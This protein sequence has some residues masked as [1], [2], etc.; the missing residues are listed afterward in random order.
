MM[1]S[2]AVAPDPRVEKEAQAL[3]KAGHEVTVLAWD[4]AGEAPRQ[5]RREGFVIERLGPPAVHGGGL[6]SLPRYREFWRAASSRAVDLEADVVHSHD[7]D[8]IVPGLRA[9][10][11]MERRGGRPHFVVDFHELYRSSRMVPQHGLLGMAARGAVDELERRAVRRASIVIVANE[12]VLPIYAAMGAGDRLLFVPNTPDATIFRPLPC[13]ATERP[14][15]VVFIGRKRYARTL[16]ALADAIQ[17]FPDMA[18]K[19]IGGGPDAVIVDR[20]AVDHPRVTAFGPVAYESIPEHYACADVVYAAYDPEVGNARVCTPGKVFEA[21]ACG[22]P[23]LVSAGTWVGDWVERRGVGLAV[24]ADDPEEIGR[25]LMQLRDDP[26]ERVAMGR[27]GRA[28]VESEFDWD[29]T[30]SLLQQAYASLD[31]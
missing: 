31:G 13:K 22:K 8:T 26:E 24:Q 10:D 4:R 23:V 20:L 2:N 18:V 17:P 30:A 28:L 11:E 21:M 14:F 5:E 16:V 29:L 12:G 7:T 27:R 6:R 19:L 3:G 9:L 25:A 15:T 1:V